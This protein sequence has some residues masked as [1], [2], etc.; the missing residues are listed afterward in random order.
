M[1]KKGIV[2]SAAA[3]AVLLLSG[4]TPREPMPVIHPVCQTGPSTKLGL[5]HHRCKRHCCHDCVRCNH[6]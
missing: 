2:I 4:C 6:R 1:S 5:V 3:A